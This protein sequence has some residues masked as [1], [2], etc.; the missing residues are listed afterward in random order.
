VVTLDEGDH[1]RGRLKTAGL[2]S[3]EVISS[4]E[5]R[6]LACG[7][8]LIPAVLGGDSRPL[9]LG[10]SRRLFSEAQRVALG[11]AFKTCAADGCQ[12]PYAWCELHH[13]QP[14]AHGG[15]TDLADAL[16]LCHFHHQRIHD[17]G[18]HHCTLPD[19]TIRF[20]TRT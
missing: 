4:G 5:A 17:P 1:L 14:W 18:Y 16:P 19:G 7:A 10:H 20:H 9:D 13:R 11:V 2:D 6:R 15:R 12:R 3:G 8:G